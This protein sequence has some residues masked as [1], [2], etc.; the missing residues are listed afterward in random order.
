VT[1]QLQAVAAGRLVG[2]DLDDL[3]RREVDPEEL[4]RVRLGD[5]QVLAVGR[6]DDP[7]QIEAGRVR[8]RRPGEVQPWLDRRQVG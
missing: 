2:R 8:G 6:G 7:V 4:G 5:D 1:L 3:L